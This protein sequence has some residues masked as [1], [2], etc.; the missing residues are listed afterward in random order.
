[1]GDDLSAFFAKKAQKGKDKKKKG[2]VNLEDVG[3]QLERKA[4]IQQEQGDDEEEGLQKERESNERTKTRDRENNEDSEWLDFNEKPSLPEFTFR[5]FTEQADEEIEEEK[6][7]ANSENVKTWNIANT[8]ETNEEK[9]VKPQKPA[10]YQPP[11]SQG[12]KA[13]NLDLTSEEM[14]PSIANADKIAEKIKEDEKKKPMGVK[15]EEEFETKKSSNK[16]EPPHS[17][18]HGVPSRPS[19]NQDSSR[20][21]FNQ[22]SSRPNFNHDLSRPGSGIAPRR[23]NDSTN[24]VSAA[25]E[26]SNWRSTGSPSTLSR[27]VVTDSRST[28]ASKGDESGGWRSAKPQQSSPQRPVQSV[29]SAPIAEPKPNVYVPPSMRNKGGT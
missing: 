25:E 8:N 22:D 15:P 13:A 21:S 26:A 2:V 12:R 27:N 10:V 18:P 7:G 29:A 28:T 17:R 23:L 20:P 3:Q 16:Y 14:F 4:K 24:E 11:G 5:D 19:F 9:Y 6:K 1:M